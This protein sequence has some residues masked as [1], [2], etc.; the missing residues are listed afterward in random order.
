MYAEVARGQTY[1]II[2]DEEVNL[3]DIVAWIA[4]HEGISPPSRR[5]T[6]RKAMRIGALLEGAWRLFRLPKEPPLTRYK[7]SILSHTQLYS[8]DKA[9]RELKYQPQ[10]K[11]REGITSFLQDLNESSSGDLSD[12]RTAHSAISDA[13]SHTSSRVSSLNESS[14]ITL[15]MFNAGRVI[16]PDFIFR[17]QGKLRLVKV[18]A[19]FALIEH[20]T[21]GRVLFDTGHSTRFY[22]ATRRFPFRL[23]RWATPTEVKPSDNASA[24]LSAMGI[25]PE[26]VSM[27]IIS[28]FDPDHIGGLKD[29][30]GVP[31]VCHWR[32]WTSMAGKTGWSALKVRMIPDLLPEDAAGRVRLLPDFTDTPLPHLGPTHDLFG[33]GSVRLVELKGHAAGHMGALL[34]LEGG[35][36]ALLCA[37]G[38]WTREQLTADGAHGGL[39][40]L[41]AANRQQQTQT[42]KNLALFKGEHPQVQYLP[43]HCFEAESEVLDI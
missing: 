1:L 31:I 3:W 24:Q 28:H 25:E 20:P 40:H 18:P 11:W 17:P 7:A 16:A 12:Q 35:E 36:Q 9:R 19:M 29:F 14:S 13:S 27:I 21:V 2:G 6:I 23:Y 30:A 41:I 26:S 32:A 10:I 8:I 22:D 39:H 4:E 5:M 37:D 42:Y 38:I 15:K 33:D 43:C 34:S